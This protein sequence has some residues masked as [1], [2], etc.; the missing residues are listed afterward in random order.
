MG[1]ADEVKRSLRTS[2]FYRIVEYVRQQRELRD[3]ERR[4]RTGPA[5]HLI[6]QAVIKEFAAKFGLPTLIETGTYL[7]AMVNAMKSCFG[8]IIS[9]ELDPMLS[10]RARRRFT[11]HRH[12]TILQGDSAEV[13]PRVLNDVSSPCLFWLDGHFSGGITAKGKMDSP[14]IQELDAILSHPVEDHV[15]LVDDAHQFDGERG[16]PTLEMVQLMVSEAR[17]TRRME[18]KDDIIRIYPETENQR[19]RDHRF[20]SVSFI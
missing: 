16:Y 6:K 3:W 13:I 7:G 8:R 9:I 2:R 17:S 5:P 12:I 11:G 1:L 14:V 19:K 10:E 4:G 15:I 18:V 20:S